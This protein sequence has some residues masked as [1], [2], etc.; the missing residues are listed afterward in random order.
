MSER[1]VH[2]ASRIVTTVRARRTAGAGLAA[3]LALGSVAVGTAAVAADEPQQVLQSVD[4]QLGTDGGVRSVDSKAL[5]RTEGGDPT[6]DEATHD[7]A[8]AASA[9]P[10][11]ITTAYRLGDR[12]GTDLADIAGESGRV[13]IDV[14]VQNTTVKPERISYDSDGVSKSRFALV[15]TPLTV[16]GSG[17]LVGAGDDTEVITPDSS[18]TGPATNGILSFSEGG[19]PVVQWAAVLAPPRLGASTTFRL[20]QET[21]E[22]QPPQLD[23]SVQPGLLTDTSVRNLLDEAFSRDDDSAVSMESRTI[24]LLGEVNTVLAEAGIVLNE[25]QSGLGESAAQLGTQTIADLRASSSGVTSSLSGL[26]GDLESMQNELGSTL[27]TGNDRTLKGLADTLGGVQSLLGD[28][29]TTPHP[30]VGQVKGCSIPEMAKGATPS[31]LSQLYLVGA[32]LDTLTKSS[33]ACSGEIEAGLRDTIGLASDAADCTKPGQTS[34][35]CVLDRAHAGLAQKA[36]TVASLKTALI[37]D[38]DT[39]NVTRMGSELGT[40]VANVKDIQ[41]TVRGFGAG[42]ATAVDP[43]VEGLSDLLVS[44]R[45]LDGGLDRFDVTRVVDRL[46]QISTLADAQLTALGSAEAPDSVLGRAHALAGLV[47]AVCDV[48]V[49]GAEEQVPESVATYLDETRAECE[50]ADVR[51]GSLLE[52]LGAL[53]DGWAQARDLADV[54]AISG[55]LTRSLEQLRSQVDE[56]QLAVADSLTADAADLNTTV[57][58]VRRKVRDLYRARLD[59]GTA[60]P[61]A[62]AETEPA[63]DAL[64]RTYQQVQCNTAGMVQNLESGFAE[65]DGALLESQDDLATSITATDRARE[66]AVATARQL[67]TDLGANLITASEKIQVSGEAQVKRMRAGLDDQFATFGKT[68][69]ETTTQAVDGI[70]RNVGTANRDLNASEKMLTGDIMRVL[71]DLGDRER[72][73]TGVLGALVNGA[74]QTGVARQQVGEAQDRSSA[75]GNVRSQQLDRVFLQQAQITRALELADQFPAFDLDLPVG[76]THLTVFSYHLSSQ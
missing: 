62:S 26:A 5:H 68:L 36:L 75:F 45:R 21:P 31:V 53:Q 43:V 44:I 23:I 69:D 64:V 4:V 9:L 51:T 58:D 20:V 8:E 65:V 30:A 19:D 70:G 54:S 56:L 40:L 74:A 16:I 11:R 7:P 25:I 39:A 38:L 17:V 15:G 12:A 72:G 60:C 41:A 37:E 27:L 29:R 28:A 1:S 52:A 46:S 42:D 34:A 57:K 3:V 55:D 13:V 67:T 59:Q 73:G 24:T 47:A 33:A 61:D 2:V 49:P 63:L 35:I 50:G 76:S 66:R 32:Q 48:P 10:V 22:F 71:I 14:T 6:A 18:S